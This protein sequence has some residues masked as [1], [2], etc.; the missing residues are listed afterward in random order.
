[1]QMNG[2]RDVGLEASTDGVRLLD[3]CRRIP[4]RWVRER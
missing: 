2:C 1:M 3:G 4:R